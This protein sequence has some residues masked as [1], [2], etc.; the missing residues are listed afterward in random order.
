MVDNIT[1]VSR[2]GLRDW[3]IQR[4]SAVLIGIYAI[5]L[6]IYLLIHPNLSFETWQA[7]FHSFWM[8]IATMIVLVSILYHAWIGLWIVLTDYVKC[9]VVRRILTVLV[10]LALFSCI[11]WGAMILWG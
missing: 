1:S 7:L 11:V 10:V 4:V 9:S 8:R 2:N 3:F 5:F 6:I